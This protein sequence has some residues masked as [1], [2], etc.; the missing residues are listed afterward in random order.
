VIPLLVAAK[1]YYLIKKAKSL[2]AHHFCTDLRFHP[3][4]SMAT[5][6]VNLVW[7]LTGV[8]FAALFETAL[9]SYLSAL[10]LSMC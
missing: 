1:R 7:H 6:T 9:I 4:I 3:L 10:S 8:T 5:T 2:K